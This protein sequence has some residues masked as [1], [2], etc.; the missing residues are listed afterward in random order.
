MANK[1]TQTMTVS[2]ALEQGYSYCL[3]DGADTVDEIDSFDEEELNDDTYWICAK[4]P[5]TPTI[6]PEGLR[7]LIMEH[8][9]C[10]EEFSSDLGNEIEEAMKGIDLAKFQPLSDLIAHELSG[11]RWWHAT[12]IQ[13]VPDAQ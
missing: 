13:L 3:K 2:E 9:A 8:L 6:D 1:E 5:L 4:E 11:I 10:Q 12:Q 7:D